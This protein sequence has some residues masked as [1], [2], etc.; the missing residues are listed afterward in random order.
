MMVGP[1]HGWSEGDGLYLLSALFLFGFPDGGS[2]LRSVL[3]EE[4]VLEDLKRVS[5]FL[6]R[7]LA[8]EGELGEVGSVRR[9]DA[10]K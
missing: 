5:T 10:A 6:A 7:S 9:C 1:L 8:H 2:E 3:L 4:R